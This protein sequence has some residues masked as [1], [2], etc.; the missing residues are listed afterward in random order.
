MGFY[1]T[2]IIYYFIY[3]SLKNSFSNVTNFIIYLFLRYEIHFL[4]SSIF[5]LL[6]LTLILGT[7][8]NEC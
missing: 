3:Y 4:L 2:L 1:C 5:Y 8:F 6:V 7:Q